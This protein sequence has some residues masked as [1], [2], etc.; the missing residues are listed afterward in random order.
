MEV[1]QTQACLLKNVSRN[2]MYIHVKKRAWIAR[3]GD[4]NTYICIPIASQKTK[5]QK[6]KKP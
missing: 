3:K 6:Y 1:F 2:Y 4:A 5:K